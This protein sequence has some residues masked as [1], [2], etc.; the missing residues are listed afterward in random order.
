[1]VGPEKHSSGGAPSAHAASAIATT[2]NERQ[3]AVMGARRRPASPG[4]ARNI[5]MALEPAVTN[6]RFLSAASGTA[7]SAAEIVEA[8]HVLLDPEV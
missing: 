6:S 3:G 5:A 8:D 1:M 4:H 7:I 2:H